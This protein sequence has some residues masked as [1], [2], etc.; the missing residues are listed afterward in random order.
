MGTGINLRDLGM[1]ELVLCP[2]ALLLHADHF[3][4]Q[5]LHTSGSVF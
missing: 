2:W 1:C 4:A 5:N 3:Q